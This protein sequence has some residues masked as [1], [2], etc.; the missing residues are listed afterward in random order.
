MAATD[1]K[2]ELLC[3]DLVVENYLRIGSG[4]VKCLASGQAQI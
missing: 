3:L 1:H 2:T 4:Q